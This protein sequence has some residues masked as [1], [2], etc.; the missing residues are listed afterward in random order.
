MALVS[1]KKTADIEE[2]ILFCKWLRTRLIYDNK[3]VLGVETGGT[4]SGKSYRDLRKAELWYK[5]QFN[6]EF[7]TENICFS[8]HEV[9]KR[10]VSGN[11]KKGDIIIFEEAGANMGSLD[12]QNKVCKL[13][14]YVL[15]SFRSMNIGI[16]FNLPY[17]S[18]LN[19]QARM[20]MH[21]VSESVGIDP[22]TN[23]NKSKMFFI[24]INQG[25]GKVY[26]KFMR[27]NVGGKIRAVKRMTWSLPSP[28]LIE[29]Y[30]LKKKRFLGKLTSEFKDKLDEIETKEKIRGGWRELTAKQQEALILY[31]Q[32]M[33]MAE[34]GRKLNIT[35]QAFHE[36]LELCGK[37]GYEVRRGNKIYTKEF[38]ESKKLDRIKNL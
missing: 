13:F 17:L 37:K 4:G 20:L 26:K 23:K 16:F 1:S 38:F 12:F 36:R 7:P 14:T 21:Y 18:M 32:G 22:K 19:K 3:N 8:V 28:E 30:E 27:A 11:L 29:A 31:S 34:G 33:D 24:Q 5:F 9:M 15:Q 6:K 35:L 2:G 10:L 25:T